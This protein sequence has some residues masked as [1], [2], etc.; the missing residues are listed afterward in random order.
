MILPIF[1]FW[2]FN[3]EGY[4]SVWFKDKKKCSVYRVTGVHDVFSGICSFKKNVINTHT[5]N[6]GGLVLKLYQTSFSHHFT[7]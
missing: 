7:L 2:N 4:I 3:T 6:F 5:V 1:F